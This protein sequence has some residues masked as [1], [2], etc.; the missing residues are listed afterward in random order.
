MA[1]MICT[2][3]ALESFTCRAESASD[4]PRHALGHILQLYEGRRRPTNNTPHYQAGAATWREGTY[5]P[6]P[7]DPRDPT[8]TGPRQLVGAE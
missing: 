8:P 4:W 1:A 2:G 3:C 7:M 5:W 6:I